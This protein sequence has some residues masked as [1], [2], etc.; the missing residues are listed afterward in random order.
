M[1][2]RISAQ[3][4]ANNKE[5]LQQRLQGMPDLV[6]DGILSRFT[7]KLRGSNEYVECDI[8][9]EFTITSTTERGTRPTIRSAL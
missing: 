9:H 3:K 6:V 5:A 2:F 7:E 1:A 4:M 8:V